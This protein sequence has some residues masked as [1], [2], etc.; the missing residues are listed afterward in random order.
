MRPPE[1]TWGDKRHGHRARGRP[2]RRH[3][4]LV[5]AAPVAGSQRGGGDRRCD[6]TTPSLQRH[7]THARAWDQHPRRAVKSSRAVS[8][9][10]SVSSSTEQRRNSTPAGPGNIPA[11]STSRAPIERARTWF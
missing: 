1:A 11:V 8:S 5:D 10:S 7:A 2:H 3:I 9:V 6:G 4:A